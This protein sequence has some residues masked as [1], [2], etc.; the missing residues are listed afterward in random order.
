[1]N[2]KL[3][4]TEPEQIKKEAPVRMSG[5]LVH[6]TSFPSPYGIGDLG[7]GAYDFI[8]FLAGSGQTLWQVL[9]LG[10][11]GFG[12]SP[13]QGFSAFAGQPLI[14]SPDLLIK[15]NLLTKQD[16][17]EEGPQNFDPRKVDYGPAIEFKTKLLKKAWRSFT[18]TPDKTMLEEFE[19]FC[20]EE[21]YWLDD[22]TL[23]MA[24]KDYHE[25]RCWLDWEKDI[26]NPTDKTKK[27]YTEKLGKEIGYY[28]FIQ[29]IF[30]KQWIALRDYAHEKGIQIIGDIPIFVALDS[31]DVWA[32]KKLFQLDTKGYPTSVA[33]VP[34]DY[35]SATGQLWG[36]PLYDW[37]YHK[38][39]G[40]KWWI[41]RIRRQLTLTDYLRI[42]HFRGFEAYWSVPAGEETAING[43]WIKGPCEDLFHA[44]E[45]ALGSNLPIFAED[46]GIIT[47]EVEHL[48]DSL[49]FPGMKVLQFGFGDLNDKNY[50]PHFYTNPNCIC[51]TGTHDND[52][53]MGWYAQQPEVIRDRVRRYGNTDGNMVSLDF[54]RFCMASIAKYAIFPIQDLCLMGSDARMNTPG[55]AT[56]N[57]AFRYVKEDLTQDR[58]NWLLK[59]TRLFGRCP[60][61]PE[62]YT[63]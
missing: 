19:L 9:P 39:T 20:Q 24:C 52:T 45:K 28:R 51:Y 25:G 6:P 18:H 42:D 14:I 12:D 29:F 60:L 31:T 49:G 4:Q 38:T 21:S 16:I 36:N 37:N 56:A 8:D 41:D 53:T 22:Y 44:I 61:G 30:Q 57:W 46:L 7:P 63:L 43:K 5:I 55:V 59:T 34:P 10:P 23:F 54:I 2:T 50:V 33:G 1:M 47:P 15:A 48:R 13:Y 35:F 62:D 40:Y 17:E 58:K 27:A 32:N 11:T 3:A 26:L